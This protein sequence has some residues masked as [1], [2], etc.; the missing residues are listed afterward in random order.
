M[1]VTFHIYK[2]RMDVTYTG[3]Y[4]DRYPY[5]ELNKVLEDGRMGYEEIERSLGAPML[6]N[7]Q[8]PSF[9]SDKFEEFQTWENEQKSLA[10]SDNVIHDKIDLTFLDGSYKSR[11][12]SRIRKKLKK[13][14]FKIFKGNTYTSKYLPVDEVAYASGWF[15]KESFFKKE[16][17]IAICTTKQ[18]MLNFFK[19]YVN[20][21][22]NWVHENVDFL[23]DKW[24]DGCIFMCIW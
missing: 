12:W 7:G 19:K 5:N 1:S 21:K 3:Y 24:E 9:T 2:P 14:G 13:F 17:T 10:W 8:A 20:Y 4:M 15:L 16:S 11:S 6:D 18:E 23:V 22:S